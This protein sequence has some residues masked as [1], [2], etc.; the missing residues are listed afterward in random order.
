MDTWRK[1]DFSYH[2]CCLQSKTNKRETFQMIC[3]F[4]RVT[5]TKLWS[6]QD[7]SSSNWAMSNRKELLCFPTDLHEKSEKI[8]VNE[9]TGQNIIKRKQDLLNVIIYC[10]KCNRHTHTHTQSRM[11]MH[12]ITLIRLSS[13]LEFRIHILLSPLTLFFCRRVL[14]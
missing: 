1:T 2:S 12:Q 14:F 8:S 3:F 6:R 13:I 10:L 11:N 5:L 9:N 4:L 7:S